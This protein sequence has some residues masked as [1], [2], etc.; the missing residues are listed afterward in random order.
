MTS[1][2]G[3]APDDPHRRRFRADHTGAGA[4]RG[5]GDQEGAVR[6]DARQIPRSHMA[7]IVQ[8]LASIEP[9]VKV[10]LVL[11][12]TPDT[13][14]AMTVWTAFEGPAAEEDALDMVRYAID[15]PRRG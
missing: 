1:G 13:G 14:L 10:L 15:A 12:G 7:M 11:N 3:G 6:N 5:H 4:T 2:P 8:E 9:N